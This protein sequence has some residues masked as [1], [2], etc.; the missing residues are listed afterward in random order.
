M[1]EEVKKHY[2]GLGVSGCGRGR[3]GVRDLVER[4]S[5]FL[6]GVGWMGFA[7]TKGEELG[8]G[9][10][11]PGWGAEG[12]ASVTSTGEGTCMPDLVAYKEDTG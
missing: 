7:E 12:A 5:A 3:E 1:L 2:S 6:G 11:F 9:Q 10:V 8:A 4:G